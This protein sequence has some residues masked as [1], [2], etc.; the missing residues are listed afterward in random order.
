LL[1][2]TALLS[3]AFLDYQMRRSP[4]AP[5]ISDC[6]LYYTGDYLLRVQKEITAF[7]DARS[8]VL[9]YWSCVSVTSRVNI[10]SVKKKTG[11]MSPYHQ[12]IAL[13]EWWNFFQLFV[14]ECLLDGAI[15]R[16]DNRIPLTIF[17]N[18]PCPL[19]IVKFQSMNSFFISSDGYVSSWFLFFFF[20]LTY[21]TLFFLSVF[22]L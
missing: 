11:A 18:S 17:H 7:F 2:H 20:S 1:Y 21:Y 16:Y 8:I 9:F 19:F 4:H 10:Y 15:V 12:N 13:S 14:R 5:S 6:T 22:Y 3:S